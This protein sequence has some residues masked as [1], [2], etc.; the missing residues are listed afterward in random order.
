MSVIRWPWAKHSPE[1]TAFQQH[2]LSHSGEF[3]ESPPHF[4]LEFEPDQEQISNQGGPDLDPYRVLGGPVKSFDLQVLLD[5][6]KKEFYLP[7]A[8]VE[9]SH[10]ESWQIQP[11]G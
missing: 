2:G 6:L 9:L 3:Q 1:I 7:A 8:A 5:P 10:L 4:A 11:V